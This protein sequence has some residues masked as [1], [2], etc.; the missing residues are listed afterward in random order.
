MEAAGAAATANEKKKVKR[1][2]KEKKDKEADGEKASGKKRRYKPGRLALRQICKIQGAQQPR[3]CL[4]RANF[5]RLVREI[6]G[7]TMSNGRITKNALIALQE[8]AEAAVSQSLN[9]ANALSCDL[10]KSSTVKEKHMRVARNIL[11]HSHKIPD[12]GITNG[13]LLY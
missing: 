4:P 13:T 11:F 8:A 7:D 1:E 10:N 9:L 6:L 12:S 2:K 3:F 5:N